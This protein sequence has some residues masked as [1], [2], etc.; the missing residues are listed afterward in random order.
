MKEG[1]SGAFPL[2]HFRHVAVQAAAVKFG[3]WIAKGRIGRSTAQAPLAA[4][5]QEELAPPKAA[6]GRA[7]RWQGFQI[8]QKLK[9]R[10][11]GR[12]NAHCND[13]TTG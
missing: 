3:G 5:K 2:R 7:Y 8:N 12:V 9:T 6:M 1:C 10:K 11:G 13:F 4:L